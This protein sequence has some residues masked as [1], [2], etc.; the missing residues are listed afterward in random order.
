MHTRCPVSATTSP[1]TIA[2]RSRLRARSC[3]SSTGRASWRRAARR[4]SRRAC[5]AEELLGIMPMDYEAPV[6]MTRGD[7]AHRRRLRLPRVQARTTA[8]RPCAATSAV[9][10]WPL[11]IITNNGPIDPA[12]ATKAT[13]FI[14]ACCQ[15]RHA[16]PLPA[17]HHRL[18]GRASAR[19]GRHDQARLEDDPGG[20]QRHGAADHDLTAA[21][22][23]APATTACAAAASI[24]ASCFSWPNAKTAVMGGEQAARDDGHRQRGG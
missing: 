15:S 6:D 10:G 23:S 5:D 18:H 16:D 19:G 13:H 14:Q 2:T 24:R 11:G 20:D 17:E 7:R 21:R 1:R 9:Q 8:R 12:G 3:R 22:R 4:S